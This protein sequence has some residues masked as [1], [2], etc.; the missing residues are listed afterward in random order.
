MAG[1]AVKRRFQFALM[2]GVAA[3]A[4]VTGPAFA[5]ADPPAAPQTQDAEADIVVTGI[6]ASLASAINEKRASDTIVDVINAQ[7][8][9][10]L[11]DQNLAE[12]LENV[13]GVQ[14]DRAQGVGSNV[15]IRGSNQNL[16]LINGRA[17]TPAGDARGGISFDD[18]PAEL[19]A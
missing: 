19:I 13:S 3:T 15:S 11:P 9:G 2:T 7:D 12:V 8:V 6:R 5:Q 10:K 17:T 16:V 1:W 4:L 14:I 18:L